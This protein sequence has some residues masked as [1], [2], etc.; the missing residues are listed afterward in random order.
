MAIVESTNAAGRSTIIIASDGIDPELR[1]TAIGL[2]TPEDPP[3]VILH[4]KAHE[5]EIA[6][7]STAVERSPAVEGPLVTEGGSHGAA[8]SASGLNRA[9]DL[10]LPLFW[11]R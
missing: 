11:P 7:T 8:G 2:E 3:A 9:A 10:A 6:F 5:A 1:E 4:Y